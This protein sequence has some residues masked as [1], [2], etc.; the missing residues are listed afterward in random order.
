MAARHQGIELLS[1]ALEG[2]VLTAGPPGKSQAF[3]FILGAGGWERHSLDPLVPLRLRLAAQTLLF[4]GERQPCRGICCD[5]L[6]AGGDRAAGGEKTSHVSR[7][8]HCWS[9]MEEE[10]FLLGVHPN[11]CLCSSGHGTRGES[12]IAVCPGSQNVTRSQGGKA[13][14]VCHMQNTVV[15]M[16]LREKSGYFRPSHFLKEECSPARKWRETTES[17]QGIAY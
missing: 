2:E 11:A 9:P 8:E 12:E 1:P 15:L 7:T 4:S 14:Q 6:P 17:L 16:A 3:P 5:F 13:R 10:S